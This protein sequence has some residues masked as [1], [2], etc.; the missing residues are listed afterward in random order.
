[1]KNFVRK[2]TTFAADGSS[3]EKVV[4]ADGTTTTTIK[5]AT[6]GT[7]SAPESRSRSSRM[8]HSSASSTSNAG[9]TS[10]KNLTKEKSKRHD[11]RTH[12]TDSSPD[13]QIIKSRTTRHCL[14]GSRI[15][16]TEY[17]DGSKVTR[18]LE[19]SKRHS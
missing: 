17:A 11:T 14:N 1:M 10:K 12:P 9:T 6:K 8:S 5:R 3:V 4:S 13:T 19:E 7:A 15:E 16:V 18:T 2:T